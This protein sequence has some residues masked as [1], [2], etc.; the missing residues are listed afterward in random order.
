MLKEEKND[1]V[2]AKLATKFAEFNIRVYRDQLS[3]ETLVLSTQNLDTSK[4]VLVRVHSECLTGDMLGSLHCDCGQQ[5]TKSLQIISEEGGILIYLRQEGRGIGLFEK[6][7]SY[8]LQSKGYDTFEANV[9]LGHQPDLRSYEMVKT[10]LDDLHIQKIKLLTNNPSKVSEIAK[11]GIKIV[12]RIPLISRATKYNKKY[13]ETKKYKFQHLFSSSDQ[14]YYYQ[15]HIEDLHQLE[16]IVD[17]LKNKKT[18][19]LL[20]I[21]VGISANTESLADA[22][23]IKKI[24][25]II[26]ATRIHSDLIPIIHFSF[27]DCIN[28]LE[29]AK[30][31][32]ETWPLANR[33]QLNDIS[34]FKFKE[35]QQIFTLFS[36]IDVPFCDDNFKLLQS[37]RYRGLLKKYNSL[38][39]LDNSKGRGIEESKEV[40]KKKIDTLLALGLN[41]I[42]LCGGLGPDK[43]DIY[44]DIRRFY[45]IN[46]SIDAETNLK[47]EGKFDVEKIKTYL[48][49]L[50]RFD[51]PKKNSIE[52]TI[53]FLRK[54]SRNDWTQVIIEDQK[55]AIHPKVFNAGHFPS[56]NWFASELIPLLKEESDFC[57]IGCGSGV[58]TTLI[59]LSNHNLKIVATDINPFA[60]ENTKLNVEKFGLNSRVEVFTG[61]VLDS[62]N[63]EKRFDTI[64]W[65]LPFGFLDPG[66]TVGLEE[67]QVFDPGYRAIRKFFQTAKNYLKSNG[68]LLIGFSS[69]LGHPNLLKDLANQYSISLT[70]IKTK[71]M[72]EN[73]QVTFEI[74][75]GKFI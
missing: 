41:N 22:T 75:E 63:S 28:I 3:K 36:Q 73:E 7:K 23:E 48:T 13:L 49:Q 30:Q 53:D 55:F 67:M 38:I 71:K 31:I 11:F 29:T 39:L 66:T 56:S 9:L 54:N 51:D 50:I 10:I 40:F 20:K 58:I 12:E 33:I 74:L 47:T 25:D 35:F 18:D 34:K 60:S 37:K 65:A 8:K 15:F 16:L 72:M 6:I 44:F 62:I 32:K 27:L 5:L 21:C 57:E 42:A 19:P 26:K 43:L 2:E 52:Q 17:F 46:F 45:R 24:N 59:S 61:D 4:P 1:F 14:Y 69:D 70:R 64:F 68:R